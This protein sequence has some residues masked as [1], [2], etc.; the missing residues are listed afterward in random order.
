M[1]HGMGVL[2]GPEHL[3]MLGAS[4]GSGVAV[5]LAG[6]NTPGQVRQHVAR[7]AAASEP[8]HGP[9]SQD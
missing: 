5:K 7:I 8:C 4:A 2:G 6:L 9:W 1:W 3:R